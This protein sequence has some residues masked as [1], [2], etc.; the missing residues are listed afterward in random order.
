MG[1]ITAVTTA[2]GPGDCVTLNVPPEA[3]S[4]IISVSPD[5]AN[6]ARIAY[7]E[8]DTTIRGRYYL[9]AASAQGQH[10][11]LSGKALA[12]LIY[13]SSDTAPNATTVQMWVTS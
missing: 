3:A 12:D 6:P 8:F 9:L 4:I 2:A 10:I 7:S 5:S 11:Q 13:V 1:Y